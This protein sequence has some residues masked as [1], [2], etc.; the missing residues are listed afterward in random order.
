MEHRSHYPAYD[1]TTEQE[2][3]D[4][5]TRSIV[6]ARM[7][8][9]HHYHFLNHLE[10]ETL[11][12]WCS[13]LMDDK[14]GEV[15]QFVLCHIDQSLSDHKGESQRKTGVPAA[16]ILLREGL[17]AIDQTGWSANS[18]PFFELDENSQRQ[19][20]QQISENVYPQSETWDGIPQKELF[21]KI[22]T[23]TVEAYYS[24]PLVW[25]EIGFG[26]PAY[27]RGYVRA[28]IGQHDPWEA[29]KP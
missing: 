24:H 6:N 12:V 25:S 29:T 15:I 16:K 10:A 7:V 2:H 21:Q 22:L 13:L 26:G 17:K 4:A 27:P 23:L 19:I 5:H 20:M 18:C 1:V 9:E 3:W 8:R 28:A 14:R 11:R